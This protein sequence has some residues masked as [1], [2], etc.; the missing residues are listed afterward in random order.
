M[1]Y[2]GAVADLPVRMGDIVAGKYRI[3]RVLGEG[4]M[5]VVVAAHHLQL[6]EPVALKFLHRDAA[7]QKDLVARFMR[8]ARTSA[9]I[10]SEH[11]ARVKDVGTPD[12]GIPY[13]VMEHLEGEDLASVVEQGD[14]LSVTR[15][16][17]LL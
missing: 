13:I 6:D 4:G 16:S 2:H 11:V 12:S 1:R 7:A 9:K 15:S 17:D 5:G 8:E 14:G 3:E 10:K